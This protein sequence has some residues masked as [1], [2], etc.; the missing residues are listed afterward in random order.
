MSTR[1]GF[2]WSN[3]SARASTIAAALAA[4]FCG[5][6][7]L[8]GAPT[9]LAAEG[10]DFSIDLTAAAPFTYDHTTGGGAFNDRT[11]GKDDDI[12]ESLEG[13]DFTCGDTVTY[14]TKV[15]VDAGAVGAQTIELDYEFLADTT[16]QSGAAIADILG[17][18]VN[19]GC[20]INGAT[21]AGGC[22]A[23]T[24]PR[25]EGFDAGINDDG[26]STAQL[27]HKALSGPLFTSKSVLEGTVQIDD[28]EA[29]ETVV[30]RTDVRLAC[31]PGSSPTGNLQA[32]IIAARAILPAPLDTIGVGQ[33]TIPFLHIGDLGMAELSVIKTVTG[34]NGSCPGAETLSIAEGDTVKYCYEVGNVG[35]QPV[36]NLSLIDD[37]GT[38]G[39][40]GDDFAITIGSGLSDED[41]DGMADDLAPGGTVYGSALVEITVGYGGSLTNI[42]YAN[43]EPVEQKN[44]D[45]TV[46]VSLARGLLIEKRAV[47]AS[48]ADPQ[49]SDCADP[50]SAASGEQVVFCYRITNTGDVDLYN[51]TEVLD[52][53]ATAGDAGDDFSVAIS[54]LLDLDGDAAVDDLGAGAIAYAF[55]SPISMVFAAPHSRTN[56]AAVDADD[57]EPQ[58]DSALVNVTRPPGECSMAVTVSTDGNCPAGEEV[59]ILS[60]TEV[61]WC[62]SV[63]NGVQAEL[64]TILA[65]TST[66]GVNYTPLGDLG[67]LASGASSAAQFDQAIADD[68][69]LQATAVATDVY[70]NT[71]TCAVDDAKAN[72]V[73]PSL[74]IIKTVVVAS[75]GDCANGSDP[76]DVVGGSEVNYC[77][78]VSNSGDSDLVAVAI[79]DD[80][81]G[82]IGT[83]AT[84]AVG[85]TQTIKSAAV[86]ITVDIDNIGDAAGED[87][88]GFP[89]SDADDARVNALYADIVVEKGGTSMV[90]LAEDNSIDYTITVS[91]TGETTAL[92]V[93]L[94]DPLPE[95]F[96][97][98]ADGVDPLC[99]SDGGTPPSIS[100]ALGDIAPAGS[101]E[102]HFSGS[103][104][105][106][107]GSL[108]NEACAVTT[109]P[110]IY[111]DNNCDDTTTRIVPGATR[112]IGFWGN[113]PDYMAQCLEASNWQ[114]DLGFY[115]M[116]ATG[117]PLLQQQMVQQAI[118]IIKTNIAHN[119]CGDKRTTLEKTTLQSG[120]QLLAA[121][122]NVTLLGG[123]FAGY[124]GYADFDT[125]LAEW[126]A[127][128]A[129]EETHTLL[130]LGA[131]ADAFNNSGDDIALEGDPG[132]ANPHF[133]WID[134]TSPES[135]P[136]ANSQDKG[137]GSNKAA[138]EGEA[139]G[140]GCTLG[141]GRGF[142]P[143]LPLLLVIAGF[144]LWRRRG[145][146]A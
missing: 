19:Y 130:T 37:N 48:V 119:S 52:D 1:S 122:C 97:F 57:V 21:A 139:T 81:L 93:V 114:I 89:V 94:S 27:T 30:V 45:A 92:N 70:G 112:T 54:G 87:V 110:E 14:L 134:P 47:L 56:V 22:N 142:D 39:E 96:V 117:D 51:L 80:K 28:L 2:K 58:T 31:Q 104:T 38:P 26:G 43:G 121:Y 12:V 115:A 106:A 9:A 83:V 100:C 61:T 68:T 34:E 55:S 86:A 111:E 23:A 50:I 10:G 15:M 13:S 41:S 108:Q 99:L 98:D 125:F 85:E 44:D 143:L 73:H 123:G 33:Q 129:T 146:Q 64:A 66:D 88:H 24:L 136:T 75:D 40:A 116:D 59:F 60:G 18:S 133:E 71:Y 95:G 29:A 132:P 103:T 65:S 72:V 62:V 141:S 36:Y 77:Y 120:R 69:T 20:V 6:V 105:L 144:W 63:T 8:S 74:N 42:V 16:G 135:C 102:L 17:V 131:I 5:V 78:A 138:S 127:A 137:R 32:A 82:Y 109:T 107:A 124:A 7:L 49:W 101:I 140:G 4:F 35:T 118:G 145:L 25:A 128:L 67:P 91:N 11:V 46:E 90:I 76:L 53:N 3:G 126:L 113:H 79:N 84:L